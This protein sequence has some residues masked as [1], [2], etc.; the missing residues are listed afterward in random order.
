MLQKIAHII[1]VSGQDIHLQMKNKRKPFLFQRGDQPFQLTKEQM[2]KIN[3]EN[4]LG[5]VATEVRLKQTSEAEH[6]IG[7]VGE[8]EREFQKRYGK[9]H[10]LSNQTPVGI[11]G[12]QQS[13][14]EFLMT[15]GEAKILYQV[16]RRGSPFLESM[17]NLPLL[18]IRFILSRFKQR[19][20]N[21]C[22]KKQKR[23]WKFIG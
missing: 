7:V 14:D 18:E 4:M 3:R 13:F 12:L 9:K 6:F 16:D 15:D 5:M 2:E 11:S 21:G 20:I 17:R 19:F 8:N 23:S 22:N 1:G 10:K